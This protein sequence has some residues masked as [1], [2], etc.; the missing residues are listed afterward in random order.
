MLGIMILDLKNVSAV[1]LSC[2]SPQLK[3]RKHLL[4]FSD[5][6]DMPLLNLVITPTRENFVNVG[7]NFHLS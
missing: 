1:L 5:V 6:I 4:T 3:K 7:K 2:F